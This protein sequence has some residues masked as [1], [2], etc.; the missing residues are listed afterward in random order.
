MKS[1]FLTCAG[2]L[3]V[4]APFL[5]S[6]APENS[7]SKASEAAR[8][9][10]LGCAYMNQQLFEKALKSFEDAAT[11]DTTLS[12]AQLNQGIALSSLGRVEAAKKVLHEAA[13]QNPKDPHVWYA[14]GMLEKNS[15]NPD[16]AVE[17]FHRVI[18]I[19]DSDADSWYFLGTVYSQLKRFSEAIEAFGHALK[20]NPLHAS[21]QFGLSRAYQQSGDSTRAREHLARFQYITQNKL[22]SAMSL[23]YGEQG[24]YSLAEE[25][26]GSPGKV[27]RPIA[28]RFL[29]Q[30]REAGMAAKSSLPA[31]SSDG[32]PL[33]DDSVLS[34]GACFLDYDGDGRIDIFL[35][36]SR[37]QGGIALY[38]NLG[39][40]RFE[41]VTLR[42][43][44]D[45]TV[46]A[47]SC[48]AGDY[49]NDGFTDLALSV[50]N[51]IL[52]LHNQKDGTFKEVSQEAGLDQ[53]SNPPASVAS[54][55]P[56]D[57]K[58]QV[59]VT[60]VDFDHDGDLD[61]YVT[62]SVPLNTSH[63]PNDL[64]SE[65][66]R[67]GG[68][69]MWRNNGNG[70]FTR[71]SDLGLE[72]VGGSIA[73][74]GTDYNNDRAVDIVSTGGPKGA[75]IFENPREGAFKSAEVWRDASP[76]RAIGIAV[77]DFDHDGWMDL[78]FTHDREPGLTLWRNE[79]GKFFRPVN[80]PSP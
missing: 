47:S 80:F 19:D 56:R 43:G 22:G 64:W 48:T 32:R 76:T 50:G 77:L 7:S 72:G 45:V 55:V 16:A 39:G 1:K 31:I 27:P 71:A 41:N 68:N 59:G 37:R 26:E 30:T 42:A 13:K 28:V 62:E 66:T 53:R 20:L 60:F 61:L 79:R 44:L 54:Q 17:D 11:E 4:V 52:L 36:R 24:K 18:E 78:A 34:P 5:I 46:D 9:N 69:Q 57:Q 38:H 40:G 12:L 74:L 25:A 3:A 33:G 15:S 49:D 63:A 35:A 65:Q 58:A 70:T 14:L 67:A 29:D 23:A 2:V 51:R 21:A 8:L 6:A 10:N 73:A 75:A